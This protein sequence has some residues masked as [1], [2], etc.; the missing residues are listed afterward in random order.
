VTASRDDGGIF[1]MALFV[2]IQYALIFRS[3]A[4]TALSAAGL[5]VL[6]YI[7]TRAS[8][9]V[10]ELAV[11]SNWDRRLARLALSTKKSPPETV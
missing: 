8:I 7:L 11:R 9:R 3:R 5:G 2:G 1:A 10:L 6:A 4:T